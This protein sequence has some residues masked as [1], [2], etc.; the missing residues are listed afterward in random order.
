MTKQQRLQQNQNVVIIMKA[1]LV[2]SGLGLRS[3][4]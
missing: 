1:L 3:N 2:G 4:N